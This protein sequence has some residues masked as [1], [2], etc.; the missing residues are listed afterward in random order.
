MP[1]ESIHVS[2]STMQRISR[3]FGWAMPS[4][5]VVLSSLALGYRWI[6]DRASIADVGT[7]IAPI[8]VVAKAAQADAFHATSLL[9]DHQYQLEHAWAEI[10]VLHAELEVYRT[11]GNKDAHTRGR[12]IEDGTRFFRAE[13]DNQL[14]SHP[15]D[16][17]EACRRALLARWRPDIR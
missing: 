3:I 2:A 8:G 10:V 5:S 16:P 12:L 15:N 11:Y 14:E 7:Q 9:K 4:A 1:L 17:A 6:G 13:F